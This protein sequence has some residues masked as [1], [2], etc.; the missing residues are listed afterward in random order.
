MYCC[1]QLHTSE[2]R[3][4]TVSRLSIYCSICKIS[5]EKLASRYIDWTDKR[6][7]SDTNKQN[8][9]EESTMRSVTHFFF[10]LL[11]SRYDSETVNFRYFSFFS[12]SFNGSVHRLKVIHLRQIGRLTTAQCTIS[13]MPIS[14]KK[15]VVRS[16][17]RCPYAIDHHTSNEEEEGKNITA[18][19]KSVICCRPPSTCAQENHIN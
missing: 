17:D 16:I 18:G 11:F 4:A 8:Q 12:L 2:A 7:K 9:N 15:K 1:I 10:V 13:P 6:S 3:V 5:V 19:G 14:W